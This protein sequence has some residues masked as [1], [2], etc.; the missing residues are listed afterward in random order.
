MLRK[1][2][3]KRKYDIDSELLQSFFINCDNVYVKYT[4]VVDYA[5]QLYILVES[6]YEMDR[7]D[8]EIILNCI[9]NTSKQLYRI[10]CDI[11]D[12]MK[13]CDNIHSDLVIRN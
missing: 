11:Y 6:Y 10:I 12:M 4:D 2:K 9:D 13:V 1:S 3:N 5:T 8:N 7:F